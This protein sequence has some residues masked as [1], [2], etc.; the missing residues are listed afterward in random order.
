MAVFDAIFNCSISQPSMNHRQYLP[1]ISTSNYN[2]A[3]KRRDLFITFLGSQST[4]FNTKYV[5][6][7]LAY[8]VICLLKTV[9]TEPEETA[10]ARQLLCKHVSTATNSSAHGN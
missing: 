7:A 2:S 8:I 3:T 1:E 5:T 9:I 6:D 10:I 4:A